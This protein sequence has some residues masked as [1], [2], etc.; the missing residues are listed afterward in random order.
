MEI[1]HAKYPNTSLQVNHNYF[2]SYALN[3]YMY[4]NFY[5]LFFFVC[6]MYHRC[7]ENDKDW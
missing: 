6:T 2:F 7:I 1:I 3:M 4:M 5:F